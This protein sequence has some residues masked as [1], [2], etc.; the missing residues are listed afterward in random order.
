MIVH[1]DALRWSVKVSLHDYVAASGGKVTTT[2]PATTEG[3]VTR[4]PAAS[5]H[6][7]ESVFFAGSVLFS[8]HAGML[9][10][11]ISDPGIEWSNGGA[12]SVMDPTRPGS[13]IVLADLTQVRSETESDGV[14]TI[15]AIPVLTR[16]GARLFDDFYPTGSILDEVS[17]THSARIHR[18]KSTGP[19]IA[20]VGSGPSGCYAAQALRKDWPTA[21]ITVFDRLP[22][23]YGLVRYGVAGDHQGTKAVTKQF[24]RLFQRDS[25][26]FVGNVEIGKDISLSDLR[27]AYDTVV[28]ATGLSGDRPLNI[29][30]YGLPQVYRSGP[31]TR[32]F[33]GHPDDFS[34]A[35]RFGRRVVIIGNGNVAIDLVRLLAKDPAHFDGTDVHADVL[36]ITH[37]EPIERIVVV[38]RSSAVE[39]KFDPVMIAEL[40]R[41]PDIQFVIATRAEPLSDASESGRRRIQALNDLAKTTPSNIRTTV[42]FHFGWTAEKVGGSESVSSVLFGAS[43]GS[44][45]K[46]EV[47]ADSVI[48]AV[49]FQRHPED[50]FDFA[51]LATERGDPTTGRLDEGLYGVGWFRRGPVGTIPE[52]RKD[53]RAVAA[54]ITAD[55]TRTPVTSTRPG[56]SQLLER[57]G[58]CTTDFADWERIDQVERRAAGPSRIR[59]KLRSRDALLAATASAET[60]NERNEL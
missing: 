1:T 16:E 26:A 17:Y 4:Y 21:E 59:N 14:V 31:V 45:A 35:P 50:S 38:G 51:E 3:Q 32:H 54:A 42:E 30:G 40:A 27:E 47:P 28:L 37:A 48:T 58:M 53:A 49:G 44:A 6:D 43:D 39:A 20:I 5:T 55:L 19:R 57:I 60:Q 25:I 29:P 46:L 2:Q 18:V 7:N 36:A 10:F 13:R 22:T 41:I 56:S 52:N 34:F 11:E 24:D 12:L 9:R 8:A 33:N 15:R 23:P